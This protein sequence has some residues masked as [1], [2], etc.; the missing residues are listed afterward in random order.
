MQFFTATFAIE[1]TFKLIAISP[2]FYF[3]EGWNIFDFIIVFLSLLELGLEGVSGLSVL[4]SFRLVCP[5]KLFFFPSLFR[6]PC[7]IEPVLFQLRVFKLA[8]SW[9]TLNLLISIMGK[10]VGALGNLTFVLCI[11]IFI[12]AVMGMQL[13]GKNYLGKLKQS[14]RE[15]KKL[16]MLIIL[17]SI[18]QLDAML[19]ITWIGSPTRRSPG[20]ISLI[21]CT[22][23]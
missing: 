9:P 10:T 5:P 17:S 4:R 1:A 13:F 22:L 19:Q 21:S 16:G 7:L 11:I 6:S 8:K 14:R 20:G 15:T 12:F 2:K 23:S 3:R 18:G